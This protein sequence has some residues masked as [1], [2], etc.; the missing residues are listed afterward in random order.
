MSRDDFSLS[1]TIASIIVTEYNG[2]NNSNSDNFL[3]FID[4]AFAF[5]E[6]DDKYRDIRIQWVLG[7]PQFSCNDKGLYGIGLSLE[8]NYY[9]YETGLENTDAYPICFY[10]VKKHYQQ[11]LN[12]ITINRLLQFAIRDQKIFNYI[13]N[14][15]PVNY[16]YGSF[17]D[18]LKENINKFIDE[19]NRYASAQNTV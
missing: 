8:D 10:M 6:I 14:L 18:T 19:S 17:L 13:T 16:I 3:S 5:L 2:L 7:F 15:P 11:M 12:I 4:C 1:Y 9:S